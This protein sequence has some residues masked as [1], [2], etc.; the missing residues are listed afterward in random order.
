M[1]QRISLRPAE[2]S[3]QD[4]LA[5]LRALIRTS[6]VWLV[7]LAALVGAL[8]GV[9]VAAMSR[10]T[11][12]L[13]EILFAIEPHQQLSGVDAVAAERA[14]LVPVCGGV[15]LGLLG[16]A[17]ARWRSLQRAAHGRG[18]RVRT[19]DRL[20]FG[21]DACPRG[22]RRGGRHAGH[23]RPRQYADRGP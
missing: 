17:L 23:A 15:I 4:G 3:L 2:F 18:L 9:L 19:R 10:F 16:L 6:E 20:L 22:G 8:A 11:Q 13:H 1:R 5:A 7:T 12:R 14:L 21:R